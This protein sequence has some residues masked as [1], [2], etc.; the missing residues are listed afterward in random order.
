MAKND[1]ETITVNMY[2][3]RIS[4]KTQKQ[5][6]N[7]PKRQSRSAKGAKSPR[8]AQN[9]PQKKKKKDETTEARPKRTY[10]KRSASQK[11]V[12][13]QDRKSVV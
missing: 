1:I 11:N 3:E 4:P 13:S 8:A 5:T 10:Q 12:K 2:G 9:A 6:E 7:A